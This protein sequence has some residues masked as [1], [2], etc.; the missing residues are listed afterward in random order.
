MCA[1][2]GE[3]VF[4]KSDSDSSEE[5][6]ST[7]Q[8]NWFHSMAEI[9]YDEVKRSFRLGQLYNELHRQWYQIKQNKYEAPTFTEKFMKSLV[10]TA[11]T[12][13]ADAIRYLEENEN[14]QNAM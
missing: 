2:I 5:Y 7:F 6:N 12:R 13:P 4:E 9:E 3:T 11:R 8:N 14:L 1:D 10:D